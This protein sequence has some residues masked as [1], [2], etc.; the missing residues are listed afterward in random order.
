M[1]VLDLTGR[2]FGRLVALRV[3]HEEGRRC[4]ECH[5]DCGNTVIVPTAQLING[6]NGSCTRCPREDLSGQTFARLT[7]LTPLLERRGRPW[8]RCRCQCG[9]EVIVS[10]AKLKNGHTR[11]CGC[12]RK[13]KPQLTKRLPENRSLRNQVIGAYRER[14]RKKGLPCTLSDAAILVLI[15]GECHY[16]GSPPATRKRSAWSELV[17]NGIDRID[18][19]AGYVPENVVTCCAA[20]N[21][22]KGA[23]PYAAFLDWLRTVALYRGV[24]G[25]PPRDALIH[26]PPCPACAA[27]LHCT[28]DL[29]QIRCLGCGWQVQLDP[30]VAQDVGDALYGISDLALDVLLRLLPTTP[31]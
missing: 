9:R 25:R 19:T 6:N 14:A 3:V 4:W 2:R 22:K 23:Q 7:V 20:C 13:G 21:Y 26:L 11:S 24:G 15:D 12:L 10:S 16:C 1:R 31:T 8:Y 30:A 29:T 27:R 5:C 17:Y 28:A 18:N